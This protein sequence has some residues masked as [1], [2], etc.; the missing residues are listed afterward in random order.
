M[1]LNSRFFQN[2]GNQL[3]QKENISKLSKQVAGN[4]FFECYVN[5]HGLANRLWTNGPSGLTESI[6]FLP[7]IIPSEMYNVYPGRS[8]ADDQ[9]S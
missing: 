2:F 3:I 6:L 4:I 8:F 7:C 5:P 9:R 1:F